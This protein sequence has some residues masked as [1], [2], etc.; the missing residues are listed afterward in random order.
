M[1]KLII[2]LGPTASGKT[3]LAV[4]L[5]KRFNGEIVCADSRQIYAEMPIGT[6]SP[7]G[8]DGQGQTS[9]KLGRGLPL[10]G[11]AA[12]IKAVPHHL[13][14]I[15]PPKKVFSTGQF[16]KLAI[17]T[18]KDIQKR[19][20]VP[21]LV[22]GSAFY[23]YP[24]IEGWRFPKLSANQK[25]RQ[26]LERKTTKQLFAMLKTLS[27]IRAKNI[28]RNNK[29]RLIRAIE[30]AKE[31]GEVPKIIKKP[32]FDC[33]ILGINPNKGKLKKRIEAR[34]TK[35]LKMGLEKEVKNLVKKYGW[36]D[37]LKNTIGYAEWS[38]FAPT[39]LRRDKT[40]IEKL[41]VLHTLQLAKRQMTWFKKD[42]RIHWIKNQQQAANL[43]KKFTERIPL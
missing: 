34:T 5:A 2:I 33:L 9:S 12:I 23:I 31:V 38:S 20:K 42:K 7:V 36:T 16:Q 26:E 1:N 37:V 18:I 29:R 15:T 11:S 3:D 22:G 28:D 43:T 17:K 30:I 21:F 40:K 19:G 8:Q 4:K 35:M 13:F 41:L 27:P 25:L 32:I 39:E 14:G 24:V 10:S 6:A